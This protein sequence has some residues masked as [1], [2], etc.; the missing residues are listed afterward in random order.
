VIRHLVAPGLFGPMPDVDPHGWRSLPGLER[1]LAQADRH[2]APIGYAPTLFTLFGVEAAADAD[3]PTAAVS[4]LGETGAAP[5]GYLLH[6]DPMQLMPDRDCLRAFDLGDSRLG[7]HERAELVDAFNGHFAQDGLTLFSTDRGQLYLRCDG[8]P[9]IR[10]QPFS[11]VLGRNLDPLLPLGGDERQWRGLLNETQMLCHTL[12]L[13]RDRE[14]RGLPTLGG[15]WFSGGGVLPAAR[16]GPIGRL[17]GDSDLAQGLYSLQAG[18]GS[19]ELVIESAVRLAVLRVNQQDWFEALA[20]L[21]GRLPALTAACDAL[22]LHPCN[23]TR[24]HW[25]PGLAWR[26]WRRRR[27]LIAYPASGPGKASDLPGAEAL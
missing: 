18:D 2:D 14:A 22:C 26:F 5:A 17:H 20:R 13:N 4:L 21:E 11:S 9:R 16:P 1:L 8:V 12:A 7:E 23:G 25:H 19:D 24:Y 15:L 3:L 27:P 10:T 6:A